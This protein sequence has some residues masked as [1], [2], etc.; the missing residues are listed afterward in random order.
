MKLS[1][2]FAL[3]AVFLASLSQPL[4]AEKKPNI[5]V[6]FTDDHGWADLGVQGIESDIRTPSKSTPSFSKTP[7][8][9]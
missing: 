1:T 3:S 5:I 7:L 4:F 8:P 6:I 2:A 9:Q